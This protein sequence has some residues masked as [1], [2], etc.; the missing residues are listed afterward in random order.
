MSEQFFEYSIGMT[1]DHLVEAL[2]VSSP[3]GTQVALLKLLSEEYEAYKQKAD[4]LLR[5]MDLLGGVIHHNKVKTMNYA[6]ATKAGWTMTDDGFWLPPQEEEED[7]DSWSAWTEHKDDTD[8][9]EKL[10]EK[11]YYRLDDV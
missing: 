2:D 8:E 1:R 9:E 5:L 7:Y 11:S 10:W 4:D 6:E 3:E